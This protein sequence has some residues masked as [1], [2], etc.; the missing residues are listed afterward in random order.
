MST[1]PDTAT[2]GAPEPDSPVAGL[3]GF[4]HRYAEVN[5]VRL[6]YVIGG[7]GPAVLL[8]HGWP[9]TWVEWRAV[10]PLLAGAGFTVIAPDLRG[11][12]DSGRPAG[13][14][15]KR[16]EAE[17][18]HQLVAGGEF[19][20][21]GEVSVVG[22]DFGTMVA[23]AYAAAYP[24]EVARLVLS[25]AFLPGFG[26]EDHMNPATGGSWHFGFHAARRFSREGRP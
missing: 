6:H 25:E 5:G 15:T 21:F 24:D 17:D 23:H 12:G 13:R 9:F 2:A 26:L 18:L 19:G 8:I 14:Y 16:E 7:S 4:T 11:S 22:T 20:E 10:M 1:A 3:M